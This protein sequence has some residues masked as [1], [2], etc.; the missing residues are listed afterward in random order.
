MAVS[1]TRNQVRQRAVLSIV[2]AST[3]I[4]KPGSPT[5]GPSYYLHPFLIARLSL[6][7]GDFAKHLASPLTMQTICTAIVNGFSSTFSYTLT[8]LLRQSTRW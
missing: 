8:R 6:F 3:I 7:I 4:P 5:E 1:N 2:P